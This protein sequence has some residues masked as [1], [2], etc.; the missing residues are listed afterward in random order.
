MKNNNQNAKNAKVQAQDRDAIREFR[1]ETSEIAGIETPSFYASQARRRFDEVKRLFRTGDWVF[2]GDYHNDFYQL[3]PTRAFTGTTL[4]AKLALA[5]K[6][7]QPS[8]LG[9]IFTPG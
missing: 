4:N 5:T 1:A 8:S 9:S 3:P 7:R 6:R 2:I